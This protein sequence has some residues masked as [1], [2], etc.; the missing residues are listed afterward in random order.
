MYVAETIEEKA[1][2]NIGSYERALRDFRWEAAAKELG[3]GTGDPVNIGWHLSDRL[4]LSS[5]NAC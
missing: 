4:C 2:W 5:S 3:L 1:L